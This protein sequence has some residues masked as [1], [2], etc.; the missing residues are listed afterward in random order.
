M[1]LITPFG[2]FS[3]VQKPGDNHLTVRAR[4]ASD[5]N[6]LR[7]LYLPELSKT[8]TGAGTD[9]P[10]RATCSHASFAAAQVKIALDIDYS[11]FKSKVAQT[12]GGARA[13]VYSE[14]WSVLHKLQTSAPPASPWPAPSPGKWASYGGVIF[15]DSG[16]VLLRRPTNDYDGAK[17]T[18]SKG[19]PKQ[20]EAPL[21]GALREVR[22]ETGYAVTVLASVPGGFD[23]T[24]S[25]TYYWV[26]RAQQRVGDPDPKETQDLA[27]CTPEQA[28]A[29][30][31]Q[32]PNP[33]K[34]KRDLAVLD[35][36]LQV[37]AEL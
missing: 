16:R 32:S 19:R 29:R 8:I 18:F 26:M 30:I 20:G 31:K 6:A 28:R 15:D 9:Y 36:A 4:V 35:A 21:D 10:H 2:F 11:N 1:W 25:T 37:M 12:Q 3:V 14:V 22:E 33:K 7:S 34:W 17:W 27:W 24:S 13:K 5:L 23:G